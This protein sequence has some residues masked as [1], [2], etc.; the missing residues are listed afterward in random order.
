LK[1]I[2][3]DLSGQLK[4]SKIRN[5]DR[6]SASKKFIINTYTDRDPGSYYLYEP[7]N[8]KLTKIGDT[9]PGLTPEELC[10]MEPVT[11]KAG[12]GMQINGYL[13]LPLNKAKTNL[14]VVVLP[15][16]GPW[17][18][19]S[20]A[21]NSEVQFLANR[22]YAVFQVNYRGSTGYGKAFYSAGFK[23]VGGKMQQDITDGVKWLI[24]QKIA[25]PKK[26]AIMGGG[27]G[28]FSALY[29]V[30]FAS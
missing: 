25:N 20:W 19:D 9:N 12:D 8:K 28:G 24:A 3:N 13:T 4:G 2:Y 30:A 22:G 26:I 1:G 15:H 11:F 23:Q 5:M 10:A 6:D 17:G 14:P 29:G 18:R 16:D 27:F 21:Y 7:D